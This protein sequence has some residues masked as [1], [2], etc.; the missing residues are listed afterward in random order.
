MSKSPNRIKSIKK[1]G[2]IKTKDTKEEKIAKIKLEDYEIMQKLSKVN[3]K[4]LYFACSIWEG[5]SYGT[6]QEYIKNQG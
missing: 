1:S 2:T 3:Q 6:I 5:T 4:S